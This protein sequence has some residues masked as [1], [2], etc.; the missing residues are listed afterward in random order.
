MKHLLRKYFHVT[1]LRRKMILSF[2]LLII[3]ALAALQAANT[4]QTYII[5][6]QN[7][8]DSVHESLRLG[9]SNIDYFFEDIN[10]LASGILPEAEVQTA[11]SEKVDYSSLETK[12]TLRALERTIKKYSATRP[13]VPKVYLVNLDNQILD[14]S[15]QGMAAP[16]INCDPQTSSLCLSDVHYAPYISQHTPVISFEKNIYS[17][18]TGNQKLGRLIVDMDT[19]VINQ[20]LYDFS[21]PM[22]GETFLINNKKTVLCR[23]GKYPL[24]NEEFVNALNFSIS[25][26]DGS[27]K[28]NNEKFLCLT[29]TSPLTG[30]TLCALIPYN[31][32]ARS[33]VIQMNLT[34]ILFVICI[35]AAI[36][37]SRPIINS[38]YKPI[39]MLITSMKEVEKGNLNSFVSYHN[40]DELLSLV[41]G[42]NSML[43]QIRNLIEQVKN[44]ERSKRQA[45]L[46]ALQAQINPHFL[47][48][49]LN[50]IR[51]LAKLH[52]TP[53]IRDITVSL[54]HL[55]SASLASDEF[56]TI[57]QELELAND[58]LHIQKVRYGED[59]VDYECQ[60]TSPDIINYLIPRFSIQPLIEN[61]LFHGIL[62][63]GSGKIHT[64]LTRMSNDIII[65]I[66]DNGIGMSPEKIEELNCLLEADQYQ[67]YGNNSF[68]VRKLKNIGIEN[69]NHRVKINF[70]A[71]YGILLKANPAGGIH[72]RLKIPAIREDKR[73]EKSIH[74]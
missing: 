18:Y 43:T 1:S 68:E 73:Y 44:K 11:L 33:I 58:Y 39:G 14:N 62:P 60:I 54:I 26:K 23:S 69:I 70:S 53:D 41:E 40:Q 10:N 3:S 7:L 13:Y 15:L 65:D 72:V 67:E 61:A 46:Y 9:L 17:L 24:S 31:L 52:N 22:S 38:M 47:Y 20:V 34:L 16:E 37:I 64:M 36:I 55:S 59:V 28:I 45:E 48:N 51:Y 74:S 25:K 30:W 5:L 71:E 12:S 50:S 27:I 19:R 42:H 4:Y 35:L 66:Y 8:T 32:F 21:L 63:K 2:S 56:I 57:S 6:E 29:E 49:T